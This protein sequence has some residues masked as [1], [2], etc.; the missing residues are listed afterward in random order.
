MHHIQGDG[1]VDHMNNVHVYAK[2][3]VIK[4]PR[5]FLCNSFAEPEAKESFN[6]FLQ[7]MKTTRFF[8]HLIFPKLIA[9]QQKILQKH[10]NVL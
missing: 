10:V 9:K 1:E 4:F 6:L 5:S 8:A 3:V 2:T 7:T